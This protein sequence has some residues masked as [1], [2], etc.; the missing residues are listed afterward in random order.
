M[1][2]TR[3]ISGKMEAMSEHTGP[4]PFGRVEADG[5]VYVLT[6]TGERSVGQV[7]DVPPAEA[8]AFFER[9]FSAL[10]VEVSLLERRVASGALSPEDARRSIATVRSSLT[11][12]NA[13][14]DLASLE[15]RLDAL[16]PIL[17]E[18]SEARKAEKA[19]QAQQTKA[20]KEAMVAEAEKLAAGNDWKGGVN[21]FR[22]LLDEWKALPRIDRATDDDLW[23]R[24]SS[25]RTTYTRRRKVQFSEQAEKR[26]DA[27]KAKEALV[28]EARQLASSDDWGAT[29]AAFRE[30]MT[31]WKAAGAAPREADDALWTQ[32]RGIQ[33]EFF[34]RRQAAH[35]EQDAEFQANLQGKQA[36]LDEAEKAILPIR[37]V[38]AAR[39]AYRDFL[40]R[41]NML[42][43]VPRDAIRA[44]DGRVRALEQAVKTAEEDE[45]RRTDPEAHKRA[46]DTA[47]MLRAQIAKLE[48]EASQ[49]DAHGDGRAAARA[50]ESVTTYR[51]WLDQ[52]EKTLADFRR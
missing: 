49:A 31:R 8:L 37:D 9:R 1:S 13:V 22:S 48:D 36:L 44:I 23:H 4:N 35:S 19:R 27:R 50:R 2:T 10:E 38:N 34:T 26:E 40:T 32:F 45:W 3:T 16:A 6:A 39:A 12:A 17:S 42:G 46:S 24:F 51:M 18:R 52:A 21:R 5:T 20:A 15:A 43:K 41:F 33:D 11:D 30:L 25:A 14:G 7:P 28:A 29:A 47:S